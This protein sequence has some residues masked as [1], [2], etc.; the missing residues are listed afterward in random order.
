MFIKILRNFLFYLLTIIS[1]VIGIILSFFISLFIKNSKK[2]LFFQKVAHIWSN[3]LIFASG[4]PISISGQENMP[5]DGSIIF[6]SNHQGAADITIL[7]AKLN[8]PFRFIIKK[9]LFNIP[10]FGWYLKK[11][12]YIP[13]DRGTRKGALLMFVKA[14]EA[15]ENNENI[16]IFPE[17][18]RSLDGNL[19][20]FKRGSM[21]LAV[22]TKK[23]IIPIAIS[24]SFYILP[25]K[26]ILIN[27]VPV[28]VTIGKPIYPEVYGDDSD[29]ANDFIYSTIKNM[30]N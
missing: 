9:E 11:A 20:P 10:V 1:F 18:T 25:K 29:K 23:A 3:L 24:G 12:G 28:K 16:L 2:H 6:V 7:L 17:G 22:N 15:L 13:V 8:V 14:K 26:S 5:K 4:I 19:Q 30:L 21:F 27:A